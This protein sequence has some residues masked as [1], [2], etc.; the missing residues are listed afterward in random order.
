MIMDTKTY[1]QSC[2]TL[3]YYGSSAH[4]LNT[5]SSSL[6]PLVLIKEEDGEI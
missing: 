2:N 3:T 1:Y 4:T 5:S 6:S